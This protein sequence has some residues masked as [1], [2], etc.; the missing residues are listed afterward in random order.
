MLQRLEERGYI[1]RSRDGNDE[2]RVNI[3]LT[4]AGKKLEAKASGIIKE[5][6]RATGL[7]DGE[8]ERVLASVS[9]LRN[10]LGTLSS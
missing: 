9:D 7:T 8:M 10:A 5:V 4:T 6:R 2:R 1:V 3:S